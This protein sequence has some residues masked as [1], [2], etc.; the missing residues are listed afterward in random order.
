[1]TALVLARAGARVVLGNRN[2]QRGEAVVAEIQSAGGTA[3]FQQT[4][5]ADAQQVARL[6]HRAVDEFG[7]LHLAF[8]NAGVEGERAPLHEQSIDS[9]SSLIDINVKGIFYAMKYEVEQ[10]LASG[11]G[12]IVNTTSILGLRGSATLANYSASKHAIIGLTRSAALDY[13]EQNIRINAVAPGPIETR[14]LAEIAEG[15]PQSFARRV[16]MGRI[17]Q[18]EEIAEA[19]LWLLSD[20]AGF[21]T[22]QV[23]PLDG[24][25]TAK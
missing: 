9:A 2:V 21:V 6:V 11:G 14:M 24:G 23:L 18:P 19:V 25:W 3:L 4:D 8:N 10:M 16:P 5:V 22:G 1:A 7:P 12:A 17:G 13:A 20:K 15:D